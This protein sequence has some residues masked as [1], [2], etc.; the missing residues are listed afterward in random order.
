MGH[1][2]L[3]IVLRAVSKRARTLDIEMLDVAGVAQENG[4]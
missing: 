4:K 3:A 1:Y 2:L